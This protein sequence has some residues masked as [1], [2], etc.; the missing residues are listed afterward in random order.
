M[1]GK[2]HSYAVTVEWTGNTGSGTSGY[3]TYE[4]AHTLV[5]EGKPVIP[6]SSDPSFRGDPARYNPEDLLVGSLSACHMLWYLHLCSVGGITVTKYIDHADGVMVEDAAGGGRFARVVLRPEVTLA[7][8]SD[9]AAALAAH[10][11]AHE[12]CYIANSVNF[13]V[14]LAPVIRVEQ[15]LADISS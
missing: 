7:H 10:H 2:E 6:G 1:A 15:A 11:E 13:P 14:E 8:G 12:K 4:R 9:E 3:R 5:A